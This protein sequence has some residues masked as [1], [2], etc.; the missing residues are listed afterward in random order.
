MSALK[1]CEIRDFCRRKPPNSHFCRKRPVV[2]ADAAAIT[3][4]TLAG[5]HSAKEA[6]D[7]VHRFALQ[8]F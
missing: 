2:I 5:T 1:W 3:S 8:G 7:A 6:N 4:A